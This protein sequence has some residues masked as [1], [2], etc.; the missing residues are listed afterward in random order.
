MRKLLLSILALIPLASCGIPSQIGRSSDSLADN[1]QK[2]ADLMRGVSGAATQL[3]EIA[4]MFKDKNTMQTIN[5]ILTAGP[6]LLLD[7]QKQSAE[8]KAAN[9]AAFKAAD[10]NGD[11]KLSASE[12][13][14]Y[15][16][17]GGGVGLAALSKVLGNL[18]GNMQGQHDE[19]YDK[20][21]AIEK[22]L[23]LMQNA[24]AMP[25]S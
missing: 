17:A 2:F 9:P 4:A 24:G 25:K 6:Q 3:Q 18:K 1:A 16:L 12:L 22:Q 8:L 10:K 11:G 19:S 13:I 15:I 21:V 23:A 14:A 5:M 20:V 7:I